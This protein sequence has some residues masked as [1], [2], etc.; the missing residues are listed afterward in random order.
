MIKTQYT[1]YIYTCYRKVC[2]AWAS[3]TPSL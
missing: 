3:G 1:W 2:F